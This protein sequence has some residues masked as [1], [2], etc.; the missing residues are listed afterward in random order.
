MIRADYRVNRRDTAKR[1]EHSITHLQRAFGG[2]RAVDISPANIAR[3]VD[4][5]LAEGA[6]PATVNRELSALKRMFRLGLAQERIGRVP[7][8]KML[9]EDNVRK[10]FLEP[11]AF[12]AIRGRAPDHLRPVLTV[13]YLTGWRVASEI[14]TR[15]W[16]HV[17]LTAGWLRL[18]PGETK[19]GEGRM[20]P[21]LGELGRVLE[22][23]REATDALEAEAGR[24]IPWVFHDQGHRI[25]SF[26]K[27]WLGAC[28]AAGFGSEVRDQ[29]GRV[30]S[31]STPLLLHDLRRSAVRNMER[32]GLPRSAAM[33][34][35]GHRTESV[36]RR[37]AIQDE[38]SLREAFALLTPGNTPNARIRGVE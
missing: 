10:G 9:R 24:I 18:E 27:S 38:R 2:R 19:N 29:K 32:A 8:I 33:A 37:Y 12:A 5:R 30:V 11:D 15:Q 22:A 3:Y 1:V 23:Q 34:L 7:P 36:Y 20:F 21:L 17:D 35:V 6:A 16:R 26:R 13:A 31:R 4:S 14:L 25:Q 28:V